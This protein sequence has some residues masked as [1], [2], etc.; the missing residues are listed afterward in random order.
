MATEKIMELLEELKKGP[1]AKE[2]LEKIKAAKSGA[3]ALATL[4]ALAKEQGFEINEQEFAEA[5]RAA[6]EQR[7]AQTEEAVAQVERLSDNDV[8]QAAGGKSR[9]E[10]GRKGHAECK[11]SFL[12]R[13]NCSHTDGCDRNYQDYNNYICKN[14]YNGNSCGFLGASCDQMFFCDLMIVTA[15]VIEEYQDIIINCPFGMI[16][17]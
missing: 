16:K 9:S 4:V 6:A 11:D 7:K 13:E 10:L 15:E 17:V 1:Q 14:N 3:E 2:A 5:I 8:A 12:D